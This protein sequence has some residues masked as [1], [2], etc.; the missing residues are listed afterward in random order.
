[1]EYKMQSAEVGDFR[2]AMSSLVHEDSAQKIKTTSSI[3]PASETAGKIRPVAGGN[4]PSNDAQFHQPDDAGMDMRIIL[5]RQMGLE[6]IELKKREITDNRALGMITGDLAKQYKVFPI[7]FDDITQSLTLAIA[8]PSN[9]TIVDDLSISLGFHISPVVA[10]ES[11]IEEYINRYYGMGAETIDSL[12]GDFDEETDQDVLSTN[13]DRQIDLSDIATALNQ[14]PIIKLANLILL[15]AIQDRASDIHVEPFENR[16]R[17]RYR[18]D[19][20]LREME[21]PPKAMHQPLISRFKVSADMDIAESRKP[22]DGRIVLLLPENR[23]AELRVTCAPTVHGESMVMRV[24]DKSM[25]SVGIGQIGMTQEVLEGFL[26]EIRKPNGIILVTGPTGSGKTTTLYSAINEVKDPEEK[27]ITTEDPV[28]YQLDGIVQVNINE[29]C[30]LTYGRCLRA[31]LRQDPDKILVGEIRDLETAQISVQAALTGHLVFSTL[32]TNSASG[33][34]TRLIDMG[35]EPFLITS[36]LQSVIGQRL[37]RT[38]CP[39]CRRP[40]HPSEDELAEFHLTPEDVAD[41]HFYEGA[42]CDDCSYTGYKGRM[43]VF[44][45]LKVTDE[46]CDLILEHATM[47]DIQDMA[48]KQGMATIRQDGWLKVCMGMTTF[49]EVIGHTPPDAAPVDAK[50]SV[51]V[52]V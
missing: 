23:E 50:K 1:M 34:I 21:S 20:V 31:I 9:P 44:E 43:G 22:Q 10:A 16:L 15:K 19:G 52:I 37:I 36:T 4:A 33:T 24:L 2:Q 25:M 48:I 35:V 14:P 28:E 39:S 32:H 42:G 27:L 5:A 12:L 3:A 7:E 13:R 18:V 26:K 51:P 40:Y 11:E 45:F 49:S 29:S 17:L 30:G 47:D 46:I 6:Y 8:D 38:I 41:M